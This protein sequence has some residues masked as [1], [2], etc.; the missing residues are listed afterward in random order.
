MAETK[1]QPE[2]QYGE[3][4]SPTRRFSPFLTLCTVGFLGRLSY[5]M[6]RTPVT[7]LYAKHLG[8]PVELIGLLVA[9][10]TITGIFVKLPAGALSD[11]FG[12]RRLMMAGALVKA[13][14]PFLYL[15]AISWPG[16]LLVRFYHGLATA[17]YAP[18]ASALVAKVYPNERGHRLGLYNGSENAGVVLGPV[19]GGAVLALTAADFDLAFIIAGVIGILALLA[20]L[21]VPGERPAAAS[22]AFEPDTYRRFGQ[23]VGRLGIGIREIIADR[24]IRI[25]SLIEAMLWMGIGSVQAYL[26]LYA[27]TIH[28]S[29][30]EIGVLVGAQGVASVWSRPIM[31]RRSDRLG[32]RKPLVATGSLLC[33][34]TLI[35]IPHTASFVVLLALSVVFGLGT[36]IVTPSTTAMIGDLVKQGNYGS[37]MGVFGSLWDM[38]HAGGPV[39]FGLLLVALGYRTSWLIMALVMAAALLVFVFGARQPINRAAGQE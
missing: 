20:M 11:L 27:L 33:I 29:T 12:F 3:W 34:A 25:V 14:G 36:G 8:A 19:L 17:V 7:P 6:M 30:W 31:G 13:S 39:V 23:V 1:P 15:A 2:P 32:S 5:E 26:P 4:T 21:R 24:Q 28:L 9:A 10:V 38:G 22:A 18:P 37:A 35:A 16:L